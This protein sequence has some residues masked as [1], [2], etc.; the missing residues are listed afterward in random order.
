MKLTN[1]IYYRL[2]ELTRKIKNEFKAKGFAIPTRHDEGMIRVGSYLIVKEDNFYKIISKSNEVIAEFINLP[3]TAIVVA[4]E[5][6]LKHTLN[7]KI[8]EED[9]EYGYAY[10]EDQLYKRALKKYDLD[11]ES[12]DIKLSKFVDS[13][14]KAESYKTSILMQYEKFKKIA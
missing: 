12:L 2:K 4:N 1:S 7:T 13:K 6:A 11:P 14:S 5:L 9:A 8:L 3:Q 10:F